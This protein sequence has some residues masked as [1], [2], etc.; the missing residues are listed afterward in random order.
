MK[1]NALSRRKLF[2]SSG[3]VAAL[4]AGSSSAAPAKKPVLKKGDVILFQ[5]DSVTD[6]R[7]A[8]KQQKHANHQAA[9]GSGYP[10]FVASGL[11]GRQ[12]EM[13]L[14]FYNRGASGNRVPHLHK[15]WK[16]DCLDLKPAVLSILIGVNDIWHKMKGKYDGT[17]KSYEEG[18]DDLLKKTRDA[19]PE[20]SLVICEPFVM[21][22]GA[23]EDTWF[24][25]FEQRREAARRVAQKHNALWV[26]FQEMFDEAIA[27]GTTPQHWARDGVHPSFAAH[28]LMAQ[29]WREVVGI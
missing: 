9:M 4:Q 1:Q 3:L 10:L 2:L 17:V 27:A 19:L 12:H 25:E 20:T 29:K 16:S 8:R 14:K 24:P 7:R 28:C 6:C 15:R 26:P 18:Y 22:C 21:R 11:L 23:V 5:G 13:N